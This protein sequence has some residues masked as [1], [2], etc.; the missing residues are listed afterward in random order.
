MF[1]FPFIF[2]IDKLFINFCKCWCCLI[3]KRFLY[4]LT[5]ECTFQFNTK[6]FTQIDGCTMGGPLSVTFS[7]IH[8]TRTEINVVRP[9][10]PLFCRCFVDDITN[11]RKKNEHDIIFENL[12]KYH[13]KIN[14]TIEVN[15]C[16]FL[17]TKIIN[18]KGNITTDVFRKT[19]KL[20]VHW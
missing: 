14:L 12:N 4:K 11:R 9:E 7:D 6:F 2:L 1:A 15:P 13:P 20:S 17:D 8:M 10:K 18:N 16:K 19:S 5:T 3:F